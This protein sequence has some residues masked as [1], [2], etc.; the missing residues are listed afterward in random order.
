MNSPNTSQYRIPLLFNSTYYIVP[1]KLLMSNVLLKPLQWILCG[2]E[3]PRTMYFNSYGILKTFC[4]GTYAALFFS[5][6][7]CM[8]IYTMARAC[9][10]IFTLWIFFSPLF[11]M[12]FKKK[13]AIFTEGLRKTMYNCC[14][15]ASFE[16]TAIWT[17]RSTVTVIDIRQLS[18]RATCTTATLRFRSSNFVRTMRA[19]ASSDRVWLNIHIL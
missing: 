14:G 7:I 15:T 8:G 16:D 12:Y 1:Q 6:D 2:S 5:R 17:Q 18:R 4:A 10:S 9:A 3:L 19:D 11:P 13:R